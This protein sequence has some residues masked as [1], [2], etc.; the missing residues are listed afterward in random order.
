MKIDFAKP[1]NESLKACMKHRKMSLH[2]TAAAMGVSK[3]TIEGWL[4]NA[5]WF[6]RESRWKTI[7]SVF[8]ELGPY[9]GFAVNEDGAQLPPKEEKRAKPT[10]EHPPIDKHSTVRAAVRLASMARTIEH[11]DDVVRFLREADR[12]GM[13]VADVLVLLGAK[14][15]P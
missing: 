11:D 5:G 8:P 13:T 9:F 15:Q 10:A 6:P 1:F 12:F 4:Y 7:A 14:A 2:A 3:K